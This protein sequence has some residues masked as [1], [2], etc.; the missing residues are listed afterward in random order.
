[1]LL[2][3]A[4]EPNEFSEFIFFDQFF[5]LHLLLQDFFLWSEHVSLLKFG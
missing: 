3:F 4:I 2:L 5:F 1:M